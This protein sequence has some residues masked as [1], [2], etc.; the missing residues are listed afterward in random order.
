MALGL[1]EDGDSDHGR[2]RQDIKANR[3]SELASSEE[4]D[5][6]GVSDDAADGDCG[7]DIAVADH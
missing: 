2:D 1:E 3:E 6:D 7:T 4:D 5:G